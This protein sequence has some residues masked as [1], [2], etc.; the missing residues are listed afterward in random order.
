[1]K[2][3]S[4][5]VEEL[6]PSRRR[7][8]ELHKPQGLRKLEGWNLSQRGETSRLRRLGKIKELGTQKNSVLQS[9]PYRPPGGVEEI[10]GGGR[11]VR[12]ERGA[13]ITV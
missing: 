7:N 6:R 3:L 8:G 10:Q 12:L 5:A 4:P 9:G 13:Y 2:E 1:M 11:R